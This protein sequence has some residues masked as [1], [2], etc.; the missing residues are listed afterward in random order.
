MARFWVGAP[1]TTK[2]GQIGKPHPAGGEQERGGRGSKWEKQV[3]VSVCVSRRNTSLKGRPIKDLHRTRIYTQAHMLSKP[4]LF[5]S[6]SR[7]SLPA[8]FYLPLSPL[9]FISGEAL[10][11]QRQRGGGRRE[12]QT[13]GHEKGRGSE[14]KGRAGRLIWDGT[15]THADAHTHR[16]HCL[17]ALPPGGGLRPMNVRPPRSRLA[18]PFIS[19]PQ[20]SRLPPRLPELP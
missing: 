12:R 17:A 15:H 16:G 10:Q 7:S 18:P 13:R 8:L 14:E 9:P 6:L 20:R 11:A 5:P 3:S 2:A 4:S 19:P 1:V